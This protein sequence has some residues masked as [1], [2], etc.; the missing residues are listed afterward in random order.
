MHGNYSPVK[1]RQKILL[2]CGSLNQTT[3]MHQISEYLTGYECYFT[4]YYADGFLDLLAKSGLLDFSILGGKFRENTENYLVNN[5]LRIDHY[6]LQNDYDLVLT[7]S[8]LIVPRNIR[9]KR[10]VL[11][12]EGMTDPR[13]L[14]FYLVKWFKFPRWIA[15][16]STNGMSN[17]FDAFCVAS[18]GYKS[19]FVQNGVDPEKISVTGIPNFDNAK[20]YEDNDFP[21]KNFV[22][23]ATSDA[24]ET[25]KIE[26]RKKI[27]LDAVKIADG[28]QLIFKLHPNELVARATREINQWAPDALVYSEGNVHEMIANCD[29]LI[30]QFSTVVYTGIALGKEVYS[31]FDMDEL[32]K[33]CPMQNGGTS[34]EK[35]A[36]ICRELIERPEPYRLIKPFRNFVSGKTTLMRKEYTA[37]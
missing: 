5:G 4:P 9:N 19:H 1:G 6:G 29:V 25:F 28:R 8:D 2:I 7:C 20:K 34:A 37:K 30:T 15:S 33:L 24:R 35:I 22:L 11:V 21:Y 13:N 23:V 31:E 26:N 10:L 18:E 12:Q 16:T 27:I 17:S 36:S 3:M 14:A 32:R